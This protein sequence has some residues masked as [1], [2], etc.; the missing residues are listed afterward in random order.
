MKVDK[1]L[2]HRLPLPPTA[3]NGA[4]GQVE[5]SCMR[6]Y[7]GALALNLAVDVSP[8]DALTAR[9]IEHRNSLSRSS[10]KPAN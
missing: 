2:N 5:R 10:G 4:I 1:A 8:T 7:I 6:V 9:V 3:M